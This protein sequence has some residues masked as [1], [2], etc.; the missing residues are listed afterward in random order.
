M[1]S[2]AVPHGV[3]PEQMAKAMGEEKPKPVPAP[4]VKPAPKAKPEN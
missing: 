4:K 1:T 2:Y 3:T